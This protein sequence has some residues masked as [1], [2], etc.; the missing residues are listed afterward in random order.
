[1]QK[2]AVVII[3]KNQAWNIGRLI[4]SVQRET[5]GLIESEIVIVD[6]NS[7]DDTVKAASAYPVR[8]VRLR[9]EAHMT[10]AAGRYTGI[11]HS[12]AERIL[13]LDGDMELYPGWLKQALCEMEQDPSIGVIT[14]QRLDLPLNT[15]EADKPAQQTYKDKMPLTEVPYCGGAALYWRAILEEVGSFNPYIYSDEEPDLCIRIRQHGYRA[16]QIQRLMIYHYTDPVGAWSSL[17]GRWQRNLY[18]GAGQNLRYHFG[19][20][21]FWPYC[22]ERGYGVLPALGLIVGLMV[23]A[24]SII[25]RRFTLL[26]IGI[27][28][29]AL[30]I[31]ADSVR[32]RSLYRT[33]SSLLERLFIVDGTIRGFLLPKRGA[34]DYPPLWDI[35]Q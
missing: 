1:M 31:L 15:Q 10:A 23:L 34:G 21:M 7:A 20:T 13:F 19:T 22:R 5:A 6:S 24:G 8:I 26:A 12:T 16:V 14:G 30:F 32:K 17:I 27:G 9:P 25:T 18:M 29:F 33:V 2:L 28:L 35:I 4:E 3:C 11:H